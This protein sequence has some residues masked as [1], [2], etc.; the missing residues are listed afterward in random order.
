MAHLFMVDCAPAA[1]TALAYTLSLMSTS[2]S[3]VEC[4]KHLMLFIA[5]TPVGAIVSYA[6]FS[7]FGSKHVDGVGTALLISVSFSL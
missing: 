6:S 1:P 4:K 3:R 5:S 7:F 2:L